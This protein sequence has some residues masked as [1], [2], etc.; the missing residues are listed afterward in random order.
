MG[1]IDGKAG[2][3]AEE[4]N[5]SERSGD[6]P[7]VSLFEGV[8]AAWPICVGYCPIGLAFGVLAQK[9]GIHPLGIGAMSLVVFAG[10]AQFI[11]VS[12]LNSGA[13]VLSIVL[14]TF[15]VNLRHFLMSSTLAVHLQGLD[16]G[17][18]SLFSYG[19][20]D[21][22]FAVNMTRFRTGEWH[23]S[24]AL[25]VNCV[26]WVAWVSSSLAGGYAG[27]FI[28]TA[29][30]GIDYALM[31][32]FLCLLSFQLRSW[33]Y[34]FTALVSGCLAVMLSVTTAGNGYVVISSVA[35]ATLGFV[36]QKRLRARRSHHVQK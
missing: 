7:A 2:I 30:F 17:F 22:S 25:V 10:S 20:T 19:A 34:V 16:R 1:A 35:A 31:A 5:K 32:M 6:G 12:M 26:S 36:V 28:P 14:T 33:I 9:A 13:A 15:V 27:Q 11:A 24:Q 29:G 4:S 8:K 18:L 23:P 3:G 21:E